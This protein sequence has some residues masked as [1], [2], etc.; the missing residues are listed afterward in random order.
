MRVGRLRG[1]V[2]LYS[3]VWQVLLEQK[4]HIIAQMSDASCDLHLDFEELQWY[5]QNNYIKYM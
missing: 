3:E 1:R 2:H 5:D 4:A